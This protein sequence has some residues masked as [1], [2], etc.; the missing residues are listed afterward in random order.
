MRNLRNMDISGK[1]R[2]RDGF[3]LK[4]H[5]ANVPFIHHFEGRNEFLSQLASSLLPES[6]ERQRKLEVISGLGGL[7]K[8]QLAVQFARLNEDK[9]SAIFFLDANSH[10]SLVQGFLGIHRFLWGGDGSRHT[11]E[12]ADL[13]QILDNTGIHE[14]QE[15]ST[16][17]NSF[18]HAM[19]GPF[20]TTRL[21]PLHVAGLSK[22]QIQLQ[23]MTEDESRG[24]LNHYTSVG[25]DSLAAADLSD[26]ED[27][28]SRRVYLE[29]QITLVE[30]LEGLPLALAQAGSFLKTT[31]MSLADY[32][33]LYETPRRQLLESHHRI[34]ATGEESVRGNI[35][36][37]WSLSLQD[38]EQRA[39]PGNK[40]D[41]A[42][43]LLRLITFFDRWTRTTPFSVG[44]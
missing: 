22:P 31:R 10:E 13:A 3:N 7:G 15:A 28:P 25:P 33:D 18:L 29:Q 43:R 5:T 19:R 26:F 38:L 44:A 27:M 42:L 6:L 11:S 14:T 1:K 17:P 36:T 4:F 40:Y 30:R 24:L 16:S 8:T 39:T 23:P 21:N 12:S 9:F 32:L 41:H 2:L 20:I 34:F 35:R 37:T